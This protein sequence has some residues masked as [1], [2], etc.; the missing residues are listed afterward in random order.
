VLRKGSDKIYCW[1]AGLVVLANSVEY[2]VCSY[3]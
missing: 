3:C 1:H 2:L